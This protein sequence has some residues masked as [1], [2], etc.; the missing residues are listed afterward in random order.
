MKENESSDWAS[1]DSCGFNIHLGGKNK[2]SLA[3]DNDSG[4]ATQF[5]QET[6]HQMRLPAFNTFSPYRDMKGLGFE[7]LSISN[8]VENFEVSPSA[9]TNA[10]YVDSGET[11]TETI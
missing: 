9:F 7:E 4:F 1:E 11:K 5:K 8:V 2:A 6:D 10:V 3:Y